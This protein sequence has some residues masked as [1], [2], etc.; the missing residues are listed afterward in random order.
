MRLDS[1]ETVTKV[2]HK[3]K[4]AS[5]ATK[6]LRPRGS[7]AQDRPRVGVTILIHR[8]CGLCAVGSE[9]KFLGLGQ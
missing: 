2:A 6:S 3:T 8:C 5:A 9:F 7:R 4:G 1:F